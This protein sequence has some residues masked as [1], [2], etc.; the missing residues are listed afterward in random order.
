LLVFQLCFSDLFD[1]VVDRLDRHGIAHACVSPA[2]AFDKSLLN[3]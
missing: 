3:G 1:D 2:Q